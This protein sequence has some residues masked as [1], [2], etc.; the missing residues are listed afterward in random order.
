MPHH[1]TNENEMYSI[2]AGAVWRMKKKANVP[3]YLLAHGLRWELFRR[4]LWMYK[5]PIVLHF[6]CLSGRRIRVSLCTAII[7]MIWS[8]EISEQNLSPT[9]WKTIASII[10][11]SA[12]VSLVSQRFSRNPQTTFINFFLVFLPVRAIC[13]RHISF[14]SFHTA[15][16][17]TFIY[18]LLRKKNVQLP[19]GWSKFRMRGLHGKVFT[20]DII[21]RSELL[22]TSASRRCL[23][24]RQ[25]LRAPAIRFRCN[26]LV[27]CDA[28]HRKKSFAF[29]LI[30]FMSSFFSSLFVA[31]LPE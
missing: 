27:T 19:F 31:L 22:K 8:D 4:F 3:L 18:I 16:P 20:N 26:R 1:S 30:I 7:I 14:L 6:N 21:S 5:Q 28:R 10:W 25:S 23:E 12:I 17:V 13:G 2:V 29:P 9:P 11:L 24:F 15:P